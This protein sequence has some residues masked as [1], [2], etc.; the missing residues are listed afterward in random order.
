M[1]LLFWKSISYVP[2][3]ELILFSGS[4]RNSKAFDDDDN[5]SN[6]SKDIELPFNRASRLS[7]RSCKSEK[8]AK[9]TKA[10]LH[11]PLDISK[12]SVN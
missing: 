12:V 9:S 10:S 6:E 4:A 1:L 8:S 2:N 7:K 3:I 11:L 5:I